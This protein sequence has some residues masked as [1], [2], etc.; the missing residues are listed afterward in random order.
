MIGARSSIAPPRAALATLLALAGMVACGGR[1][2]AT[3]SGTAPSVTADG[4]P[5]PAAA[6]CDASSATDI[7]VSSTDLN[8]FPPY[9][10]AGCTLAYV[11]AA[12]DLVVRDLA[13][14][15]EAV[16]APAT[17]RPRRPAASTTLVAWEA[18]E[19]G[20]SVVRIRTGGV[21]QTA[22]GAF[23]SAGEPRAS[24]ASVVFTAWNGPTAADDTDVW[25]YDVSDAE[26][27]AHL[28]VG[29]PGQQRSADVSSDYV[30]VSDFGEDP[31]LR[32]DNDG[33]DLA[34]VVVL[35]RATGRL[36]PRRLAGKQAF[37]ML[38]DGGVLAYLDWSGI[39]P[40]PKFV[41]YQLRS[42]A[43][44]GDPGADRSIADVLYA[45]SDYARPAVSGGTLEW[46]ANP[47]GRTT[48]YRA[49]ADGSSAALAVKG[50]EDLRLYAPSPTSAGFTVLAASRIGRA[51]S[52]PRLRAVAR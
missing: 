39:H 20:R 8:G 14:G 24:G 52:A 7:A 16:V 3:P 33:K 13:A 5:G 18:D 42:G 9:A 27:R 35:E 47:D 15:T 43:V 44:L 36:L 51:E 28:A 34:D 1:S 49:R 12:G 23:Q 17:E 38:A 6:T 48:L 4:G 32:F 31:D 37:P 26:P 46:I 30:A 22:R 45:S 2:D 29:G 40:E 19:D 50:L 25:L 21:V 10:V 11:S 41:G